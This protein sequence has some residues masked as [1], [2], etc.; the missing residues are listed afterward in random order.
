MSAPNQEPGS[1][2]KR[3]HTYDGIEEYDQRLPN[4]WL[5]T[6][7]LAIIFAVAYW[8]A[9]HQAGFVVTDEAR[10]ARFQEDLAKAK[11]A[12]TPD[13]SNESLWKQSREPAV[14]EA[15]KAT[16]LANCSPCHGADL[17]ARIGNTPL[18][19]LPLNDPEWKYGGKPL[20]IMAT[21]KN[22]SPD[23][24]KGMQAWEPILGTRRI[25]EVVAFILSHHPAPK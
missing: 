3:P 10:M 4:W 7:Y 22:G 6:F 13:L 18:P 20:E 19:G 15:G 9:W 14:V 12:A 8:F 24:T 5:W 16:F 2:T 11:A 1:P 25:G 17:S 21:V 23:K